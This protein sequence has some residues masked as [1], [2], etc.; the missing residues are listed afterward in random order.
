MPTKTAPTRTR[1][2][3]IV[4]YLF[5]AIAVASVVASALL[6]KHQH[7]NPPTQGTRV[8]ATTKA[9]SSD[10][11]ITAFRAPEIWHCSPGDDNTVLLSWSTT[12]ATSVEIL[13]DDSTTPVVANQAPSSQTSVPAPCAPASHTYHLV[14]KSA[15]GKTVTKTAATKG[16]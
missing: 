16:V 2:R 8:I 5:L 11:A 4:P 9:A 12:G 10:L 6:W 1:S 3:S 14:A 15:D 13:V 7:D